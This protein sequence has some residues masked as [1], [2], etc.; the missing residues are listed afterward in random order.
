MLINP[1]DFP[2]NQLKKNWNQQVLNFE[3]IICSISIEI[4]ALLLGILAKTDIKHTGTQTYAA[5]QKYV[6]FQKCPVLRN[7]LT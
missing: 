6:S 3:Y 5:G 1:M 7:P 2:G 4:C